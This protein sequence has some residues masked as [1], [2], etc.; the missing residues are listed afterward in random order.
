[1]VE[2]FGVAKTTRHQLLRRCQ[3]SLK[4]VKFPYREAGGA[5]M[6]TA[7]MTRPNIARAVRAVAR[8]WKPWT[9]ILLDDGDVGHT[10]LASH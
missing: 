5:L 1:M 2:K 9:V 10:L 3:P 6:W 8:F 7:T 4:V